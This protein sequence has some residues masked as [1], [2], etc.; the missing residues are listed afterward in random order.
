[1]VSAIEIYSCA[2]VHF[3]HLCLG[4]TYKLHEYILL[5]ALSIIVSVA[6]LAAE[7]I[8]WGPAPG[9]TK[10]KAFKRMWLAEAHMTLSLAFGFV[11]LW[12]QRGLQNH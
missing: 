12:P 2:T 3:P 4:K 5:L 11:T 9:N 8:M 7:W 6:M 1:M 10:S